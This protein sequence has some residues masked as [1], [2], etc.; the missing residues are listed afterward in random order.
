M[1]GN[2]GL[3]AGLALLIYMAMRGIN[4]FIASLVCSLVVALTNGLL[5]PRTLLE[6]YPSGSLGAF[7]FA[8]RF[9]LLFLCGAIFGKA[10][11][12]SQAAK[13][14]ALA[15]TRPSVSGRPLHR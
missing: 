4:I 13:A 10:M 5:I 9:F 7:S 14:I 2:L 11:A 3:L 15:I 6:Y 8:G 1:L 12:T